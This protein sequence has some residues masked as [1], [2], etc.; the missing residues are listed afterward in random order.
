[1]FETASLPEHL[2]AHVAA[3]DEV[4][5]PTEFNRESFASAGVDKS[6]IFLVPEVGRMAQRGQG[7]GVARDAVPG[8]AWGWVLP[9]RPG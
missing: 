3:M 8:T 1:M 7:L 6:K 9:W 2:A 5:V 4:W